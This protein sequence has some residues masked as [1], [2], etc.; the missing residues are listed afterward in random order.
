MQRSLLL[1]LASFLP[2]GASLAAQNSPEHI[3]QAFVATSAPAV[4]VEPTKLDVPMPPKGAFDQAPPK[5]NMPPIPDGPRSW[6]P[7]PGPQSHV[8]NAVVEPNA[9]TV[10]VYR[11]SIV[12]PSGASTSNVGEPSA[13]KLLGGTSILHTGNWYAARSTN[14]GSSWSYVNPYTRLPSIDG[15]FCCDQVC[16]DHRLGFSAWLL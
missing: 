1:A 10:Q 13:V 4:I 14:N 2:V 16:T 11:N 7:D 3:G 9:A 5:H 12:K 15:G 6:D 8:D